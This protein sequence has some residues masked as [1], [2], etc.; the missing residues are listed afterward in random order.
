M[1]PLQWVGELQP[2]AGQF[3]ALPLELSDPIGG[4]CAWLQG[5]IT[6][7]H[8]LHP[9]VPDAADL[10]FQQWITSGNHEQT[11]GLKA[12]GDLTFGLGNGSPTPQAPDVGGADVGDHR[13]IGF[14]ANAEAMN[15]AQ[16]AHPHLQHQSG[17]AAIAA[18]H[19]A[20]NADVVVFIANTAL[21]GS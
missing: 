19:R 2:L 10:S 18:Q 21:N 4:W 13:H 20:G 15:F 16:A 7:R 17:M 6:E 12:I 14:R 9:P 8:P 11:R 5:V 3:D 1:A